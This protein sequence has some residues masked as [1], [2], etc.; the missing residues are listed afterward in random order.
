MALVGV[1]LIGAVHTVGGTAQSQ[2][3]QNH[4]REGHIL[5]Q[6]LVSEIMQLQYEDPDDPPLWGT[7]GSESRTT[8]ADFDD[9]DDYDGWTSSTIQDKAGN[10]RAEYVGWTRTARLEYVHAQTLA[11]MGKTTDTGVKGIRVSVIAPNG[12]TYTFDAMRARASV[13][14]YQYEYERTFESWIGID[15][16]TTGHADEPLRASTALMNAPILAPNLLTNGT[17]EDGTTSPWTTLDEAELLS[18]T[19]NPANGTYCV[20]VRN[21]DSSQ[22]GLNHYISPVKGQRYMAEAWVRSN[23]EGSQVRLHIVMYTDQGWQY[24]QADAGPVTAE[25]SRFSAVLTPN[26]TGNLQW[27][28]FEVRTVGTT[29]RFWADDVV[30][31]AMP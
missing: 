28:T 16:A 11:G 7:E 9:V 6:E 14:D 18:R 2:M 31:R 10:V 27:A 13:L 29:Q 8:R 20:V 4:H 15:L 17:F 26:W 24:A 12:D 21:R 1:L 3:L 23:T 25:W 5:A 19:S 22:A 30:L